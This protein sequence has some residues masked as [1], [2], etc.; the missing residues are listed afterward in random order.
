[1]VGK[2][3]ILRPKQRRCA[4]W[5]TYDINRAAD[6]LRAGG[7][8]VFPTET[9][10]GLGANALSDEASAKIYAAKGRPADNPFIIHV[11]DI[12]A[13]REIARVGANA[14][15]LFNRFAPGPLTVVLPCETTVTRGVRVCSTARAGLDSIGVRIPAHPIAQALLRAAGVPVAAPSANISGKLSATGFEMVKNE[16]SGTALRQGFVRQGVDAIIDGG[17]CDFGLE[18]TVISL[19]DE[20]QPVLLRSGAVSVREIEE[21]LG[22]SVKIGENLHPGETVRSP[23]QKYAHY[24][25]AVPLELVRPPSH[26]SGAARVGDLCLKALVEA[27]GGIK[28]GIL[29]VN[30]T[31][32]APYGASTPSLSEGEL[33]EFALLTNNNWEIVCFDSLEGY[34]HGLYREMWRLGQACDRLIAVLPD[35]DGIGLALNNRLLKAAAGKFF[36]N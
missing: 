1:M 15:K 33:H 24:Q 16:M 35:D 10:Y 20:G 5:R 21:C 13:A 34:A 7:L 14:E 11:S 22:I 27:Y 2:T 26:G 29:T 8:V 36:K 9:V 28:L 17:D 6:I 23:G 19:L 30:T 4:S 31:P 12:A 25:P 3:L 18:S 32:S